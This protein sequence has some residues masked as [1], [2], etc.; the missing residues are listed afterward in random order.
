M[1]RIIESFCHW[2]DYEL[3][4]KKLKAKSC[5]KIEDFVHYV[6]ENRGKR[7]SILSFE[8]I[9][10][11]RSFVRLRFFQINIPQE[12]LKFKTLAVRPKKRKLSKDE[13]FIEKAENIP[14]EFMKHVRSLGFEESDASVLYKDKENWLGACKGKVTFN[15]HKII[16][17]L[18][19]L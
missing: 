1:E 18:K 8:V 13:D 3:V 2:R 19:T 9:F 15:K 6:K 4:S 14:D 10:D 5:M 17:H 7:R 12:E 16:S 11:H